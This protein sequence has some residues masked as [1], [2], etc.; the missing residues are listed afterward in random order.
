MEVYF[1]ISLRRKNGSKIFSKHIDINPGDRAEKCHGLLK[2]IDI[3]INSKKGYVIISKC[4]KCGAI[5]KNKMAEDDNM[6]LAYEIIKN[7]GF[8]RKG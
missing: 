6:E 4:I 8:L 5:R 1:H 7:K 3:E 2:P